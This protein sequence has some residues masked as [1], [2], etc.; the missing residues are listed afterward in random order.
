MQNQINTLNSRVGL[1]ESAMAAVQ[2]TISGIQQQLA[3]LQ[4]ALSNFIT[5]QTVINNHLTFLPKDDRVAM[6]CG[7]MTANHLTNDTA[8]GLTCR[9]TRTGTCTCPA[10]GGGCGGSPLMAPLAKALQINEP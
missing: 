2:Q 1:L 7:Y 9:M 10:P 3:G 8:F 4:T 6:V 5:G